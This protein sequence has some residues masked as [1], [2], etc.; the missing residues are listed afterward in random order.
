MK[1]LFDSSRFVVT[2][3]LFLLT[4]PVTLRCL[5]PASSAQTTPPR[6]TGWLTTNGDKGGTRYSSLT[7]INS[8]NVHRLGVA[9]RYRTGDMDPARKTTIECTPVV[10]GEVMYL[11]TVRSK[12]VALDA[13]SGRMIWTFDPYETAVA[14]RRVAGGVNRGVAYWSAGN[15]SGRVFLGTADGRLI[16]LDARAGRP[17]PAFGTA[18]IVDLR[19]GMD[20]DLSGLGYGVTSPPA[21][22]DNLVILGFSV[23]EGPAPAAPGDIRAFDVRTGKEVWRFR[24]VP[25]PGEFGNESWGKDSWRERGGANAW[26]GLT[27][28]SQRG[29]VFAGLGS[30]AFDFYGGDRIGANLF[31][32]CVIAL[33]ARTGKRRWHFQVVKHDIWDYDLPCPPVLVRVRHRGRV[34]AAAAQVTK[35]GLVF[36]LDRITGK[37]LFD[38]VERKAPA[39]G[40]PGESTWPTQVF[41]VKPPP[42]A[43]QLFDESQVT[44]ISPEARASVLAR[45]ARLKAGPIFTPPSLEG[46]VILPGFHGGANW[47]GAS[48]D[49]ASGLLFVNSNDIPWLET[50]VKAPS[51][52]GYAYGH[53][54]YHKFTDDEGYPAIKP[55]WGSLTAIDLNRGEIAW[56]VTLGEIP[57]LARRGIRQT[58]SENF[59]GTIATAGGLLFIGATMDEMFRAFDKA[60]G[61]I[62]WEH[63]LNAGGYATPCTF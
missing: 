45:L 22:F 17:D 7:Q 25:G 4:L 62:L 18:G 44:D 34:I 28:D 15:G 16:S 29:L 50:L 13:A 39:S 23:E 41:P 3:T 59:G 56:R 46:T 11:T 14:R 1:P 12:V 57:E 35:T 8:R 54:G 24:T 40:V 42:F 33:D 27:V 52:A 61:R 49:P 2:A 51:T 37:P 31:A 10:A 38:V 9:W 53:T 32:N 21:I 26:G 47:S 36:L 5:A 63:Q 58:G 43:R 20:R 48:F 60:T 30:A 19:T 6:D 55:P